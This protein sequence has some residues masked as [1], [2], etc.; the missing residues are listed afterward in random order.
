MNITTLIL[1]TSLVFSSTQI[2][3]LRLSHE[4]DIN[5][6][7]VIAEWLSSPDTS[8]RRQLKDVHPDWTVFEIQTSPRTVRLAAVHKAK[9]VVC[10]VDADRNDRDDA[11]ALLRESVL[12]SPR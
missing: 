2:K 1:L 10:L 4:E 3:T 11:L 12:S 5:V 9:P 7:G 8:S 6:R